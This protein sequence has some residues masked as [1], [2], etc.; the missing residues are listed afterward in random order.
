ML[1]SLTQNLK[2]QEGHASEA[3][4]VRVVAADL[5]QMSS[6][7]YFLV[8]PKMSCSFGAVLEH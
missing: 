7:F 2:L 5:L 4:L 8:F 3:F 6:F 1:S